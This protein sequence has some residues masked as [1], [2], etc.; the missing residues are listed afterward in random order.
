MD[1]KSIADRG[2]RCIDKTVLVEEI[3]YDDHIECV[4]SCKGK[5]EVC[6]RSRSN[7]RK[8]QKP[9]V[10]RLCQDPSCLTNA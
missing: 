6:S 10:K 2:A 7:P 9:I 4:V 5:G 1:M 8:V 3:E